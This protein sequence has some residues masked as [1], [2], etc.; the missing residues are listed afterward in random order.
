MGPLGELVSRDTRALLS[1]I[2][3]LSFDAILILVGLHVLAVLAY[4]LVR[5]RNLI[6]PMLH[7]DKELPADLAASPPRMA[8]PL[9]A[10]A[11]V[12]LAGLVVWAVVSL[13][14]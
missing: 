12:V 5:G 10:L 8:S 13:G 6:Y 2:H 14:G 7:G 9:R 1:T 11:V 3:R 4:W